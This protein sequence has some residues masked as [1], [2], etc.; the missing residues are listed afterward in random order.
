MA[1]SRTTSA[2]IRI[3]APAPIIAAAR[4]AWL[5]LSE[6]S[7]RA[8]SNSLPT[9]LANCPTASLNSSGIDRLSGELIAISLSSRIRSASGI[10][11]T[12]P[13]PAGLT[14][15]GALRRTLQKTNESETGKH[16][17]SQ[18]R[19]WLPPRKGLRAL[20]QIVEVSVPD[21]VGNHFNL[22]RRLS[23]VSPGNRQVVVELACCPAHRIRK[24]SDVF[25]AGIFLAVDGLLEL[26]LRGVDEIRCPILD[27]L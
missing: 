1:K 5:A 12:G 16:G 11:I 7:A 10:Q 23:D 13:A 6:S 14:V 8:S 2:G 21:R 4:P 22:R 15:V 3:T 18:K 24:A 27:G 17:H 26:T 20:Q 19:G 25:G 9:S